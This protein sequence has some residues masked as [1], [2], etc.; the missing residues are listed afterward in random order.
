[1]T[2]P[3][4]ALEVDTVPAVSLASVVGPVDPV[5][6]QLLVW[7]TVPNWTMENVCCG[8]VPRE[9]TSASPAL[10]ATSEY[11]PISWIV[12]SV[13]DATPPTADRESVP[14]RVAPGP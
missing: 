7:H 10:L 3:A 11:V 8:S 4:T 13:N 6:E 12:R 14:F 2:L 1:M 5:A 9:S